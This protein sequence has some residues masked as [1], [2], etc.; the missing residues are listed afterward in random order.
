MMSVKWLSPSAILFVLFQILL[1]L[2]AYQTNTAFTA[3]MTADFY[4]EE[5]FTPTT[6]IFDAISVNAGGAFNPFSSVFTCSVTG[7]YAFYGQFEITATGP[8]GT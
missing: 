2:S 8:V 1:L 4:I 5:Q 3:Y 7:Y 6:I